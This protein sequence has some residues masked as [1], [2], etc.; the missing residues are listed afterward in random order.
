MW[1]LQ[2]MKGKGQDMYRKRLSRSLV[3]TK[4]ERISISKYAT[5]AYLNVALPKE[6]LPFKVF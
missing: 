2:I 3:G 1:R 6:A 5:L 4:E